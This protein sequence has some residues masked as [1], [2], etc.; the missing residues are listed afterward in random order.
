ML[1]A[2]AGIVTAVGIGGWAL[3]R[4]TVSRFERNPD[5]YPRELLGREPS[6]DVEFIS[7]PDGTVLRTVS[8][9]TGR[10]VVL[11]HGFGVTL[12]EW[13]LLWDGLIGLGYRVIAFDQRGHGHSTL[14]SDGSGSAAMASDYAAVLEHFAVRDGILVGHSMGG[15]V[16]IRAV[17]DHVEVAQRLRGL[18]LCATWAGRMHDGAPMNLLQVPLLQTGVLQRLTRTRTVGTLFCA[19]QMGPRPS[20][21]MLEVFRDLFARQQH[22]PLLPIARAF[23]AEDRYPRLPEITVPT[24]VLVG[25]ADRSTPPSHARRLADGIPDARLVT[26]PGAGHCLNWE[27]GGP[28][29]LTEAIESLSAAQLRHHS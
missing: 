27:A 7:R 6:G 18:V 2:A 4:S 3:L 19:A 1:G 12:Q 11:A 23:V 20:P 13:N 28:A 26:V 16:A 10:P 21:A 9:G 8:A 5:P 22:R 15:F 14:G 25:D 29:A 17:L 24:V